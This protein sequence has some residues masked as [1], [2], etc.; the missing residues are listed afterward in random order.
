M[1]N[2]SSSILIVGS[3]QAGREKKVEEILGL[4]LKEQ[5][6]N[7]DFQLLSSKTSIGIEEIRNLQRFLSLKPYKEKKKIA[8]LSE[9]QVLTEEAQNALLKSLEEPPADS[10]LILTAAD[11]D[12]LLPTIVSRCEI[13]QLSA[14][15]QISLKEKEFTQVED[16]FLKL[17]NSTLGEKFDLLD[18]WGIC[19]DRETTLS[20]LNEM[21]L[22]IRQLMLSS[23]KKG[24]YLNIL[25]SIN[26]TKSY[27]K[28]NCN[29]RLSVEVF[30]AN[31][32]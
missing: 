7:P 25:K 5:Y 24:Q 21:T 3:T 30:L 11:Y 13:I 1:I 26:K 23:P 9:A 8:L 29:L 16:R 10:I 22:V 4:K 27:L 32:P 19:K 6:N 2:H 18:E 17:I 31:L 20:W 28:A 12:L 15:P 14:K